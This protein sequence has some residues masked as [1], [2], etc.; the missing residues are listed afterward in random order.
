MT[1][2][3]RRVISLRARLAVVRAESAG[4]AEWVSQAYAWGHLAGSSAYHTSERLQARY[5]RLVGAL[6]DATGSFA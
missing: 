6:F 1:R 4:A 2:E 3:E 5:T